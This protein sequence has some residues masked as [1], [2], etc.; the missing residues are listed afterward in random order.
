MKFHEN[1]SRGSRTVPSGRTDGHDQASSRF[2]Q[3][4]HAYIK[5]VEGMI[6]ERES[7]NPTLF[8]KCYIRSQSAAARTQQLK[9]PSDWDTE[10]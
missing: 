7:N 6:R 4:E 2:S 10:L 8:F 9:L 5:G 3:Y 1:P